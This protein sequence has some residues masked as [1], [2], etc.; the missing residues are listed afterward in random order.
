MKGDVKG[1]FQHLMLI[2]SSVQWMEARVK[3]LDALIIDMY[4][5]FGWSR[6]PAYTEH[7]EGAISWRLGRESLATISANLINTTPLF[8]YE[9]LVDRVLMEAATPGR[10]AAAGTALRLATMAILSPRAIN[11]NMFS[12]WSTK[13][14]VLGLDRVNAECETEKSS[15]PRKKNHPKFKNLET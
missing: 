6:S 11:E 7:L 10:I 2:A 1:A 3:Q 13:L 8:A 14:E 15:K 5:P 9:W 4:A 12:K